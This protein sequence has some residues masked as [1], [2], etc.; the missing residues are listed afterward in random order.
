MPIIDISRNIR[1]N[2]NVHISPV[3]VLKVL[4]K[5]QNIVGLPIRPRDINISVYGYGDSLTVCAEFGGEVV[6]EEE[7]DEGWEVL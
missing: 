4:K 6:V 3:I 7:F 1:D 2:E 5:V